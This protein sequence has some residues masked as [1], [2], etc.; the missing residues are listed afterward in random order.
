M[1]DKNNISIYTK[2][3]KIRYIKEYNYYL[4]LDIYVFILYNDYPKVC[5]YMKE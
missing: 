3:L 4:A 2:I 5:P 1:L